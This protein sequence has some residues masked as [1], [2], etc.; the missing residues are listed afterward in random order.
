MEGALS[1]RYDLKGKIQKKK[2]EKEKKELSWNDQ[3]RK[4]KLKLEN[5]ESLE[6]KLKKSQRKRDKNKTET[7]ERKWQEDLRSVPSGPMSNYRSSKKQITE[8]IEEKK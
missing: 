7:I 1:E 4:K 8:I 6:V 5:R 2:K 3:H